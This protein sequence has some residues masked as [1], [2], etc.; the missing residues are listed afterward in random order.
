MMY[1]FYFYD[2]NILER[3][4][5]RVRKFVV[6]A[7]LAVMVLS[8]AVALVGPSSAYAINLSGKILVPVVKPSQP[9]TK[10][11]IVIPPVPGPVPA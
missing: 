9:I 4:V 11:P 10:P 6:V 2:Y 8:F 1:I 3:Q 7:L 5:I